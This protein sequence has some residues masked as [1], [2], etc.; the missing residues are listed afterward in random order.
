MKQYS[1]KTER[2]VMGKMQCR[3][4]WHQVHRSAACTLGQLHAFW[5]EW[6]WCPVNNPYGLFLLQQLQNKLLSD[7][8]HLFMRP[9]NMKNHQ[10]WH[11]SAAFGQGK[12]CEEKQMENMLHNNLQRT[13]TLPATSGYKYV[14][15]FSLI[16]VS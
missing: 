8:G 9:L 12:L 6:L 16:G 2:Y 1:C 14:W 15:S 10:R 5:L 13:K 11:I 7:T 3:A 4:S